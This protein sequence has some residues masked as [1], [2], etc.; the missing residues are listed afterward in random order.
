MSS[1]L[2]SDWRSKLMGFEDRPFAAA[3]LGQVHRAN[4]NGQCVAV[5]VQYPGVAVSIDSDMS[6]VGRLLNMT[7]LM[8]EGLFLDTMLDVAR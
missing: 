4:V 3:S 8:P 1:E 7:R 5:K 2:G 6:M